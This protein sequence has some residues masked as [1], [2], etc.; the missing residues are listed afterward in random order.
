[1][2][3]TMTIEDYEQVY[4]LW[5][6]IHGLDCEVSMIPGTVWKNF[7]TKSDNQCRGDRKTENRRCDLVR[8]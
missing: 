7:K 8:A 2:I 6:K 3:R 5:K 4:A 1:M